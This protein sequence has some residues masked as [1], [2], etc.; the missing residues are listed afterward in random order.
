MLYFI[1]YVINNDHIHFA[2][3]I[4]YEKKNEFQS[5]RFKKFKE[6]LIWVFQVWKNIFLYLLFTFIL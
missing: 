3:R 5:N 2:N 4:Q 1:R 6:N